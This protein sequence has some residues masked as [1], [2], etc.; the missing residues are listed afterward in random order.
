MSKIS[1]KMFTHTHILF[2]AVTLGIWTVENTKKYFT[3][4]IYFYYFYVRFVQFYT[5]DQSST[6]HHNDL[7]LAKLPKCLSGK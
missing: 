2:R 7:G 1:G 3:N 5:Y 4:Y 6:V